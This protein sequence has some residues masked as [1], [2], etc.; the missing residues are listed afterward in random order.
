M[1]SRAP[2]IIL[3]VLI[4][5]A[6]LA[7]LASLH[8]Q[9]SASQSQPQ[10][11]G[12]LKKQDLEEPFADL[13]APEM[14][15]I[16]AT[17]GEK[18]P[19]GGW[20]VAALPDQSQKNGNRSPVYVLNTVSLMASGKVTNLIVAGVTLL[21]A[22]HKPVETIELKWSLI[23]VDSQSVVLNGRTVR[24]RV[25]IDA[26]RARKMKSP[27]VNFARISRPLVKNGML[28]GNYQL[29]IGVGSIAFADGSSWDDQDVARFNHSSIART[30]YQN[31]A[32][33]GDQI[34]G[35]GPQ[36][37]E[38][39]CWDQPMSGFN[40]RLINCNLQEGVTYCICDLKSCNDTCSFTQAQEDACNSQSCHVFDEFFC[41][42]VDNSNDPFC[43]PNP[44]VCE[45]C[46][47]DVQCCTGE[48]CN[49]LIEYCVG[50]YY[51]GCD[52][53]FVDD[54]WANGGYV[55]VGTCQ[56]SYDY[57]GG[58]GGGGGGGDC[59]DDWE[60]GSGFCDLDGYCWEAL[61]DPILIDIRG[62]GFSMTD[63]ANGVMFDFFGNGRLRQ[64][65]WTEGGSD[66]AWLVFDRDKNG[67]I[68]NG[69]ELFSNVSP[70]P[71]PPSGA[72]RI[73]F[74][75]LAMFDKPPLGG[76]GDGVIDSRD[77]IFSKLRLWQDS[78]HNGISEPSE[79]HTLEELG[80]ES[81]SLDYRESRRTDRYGN[82]FRYRAKVYGTNHADLGRWAY[83]VVLLSAKRASGQ[84]SNGRTNGGPNSLWTIDIFR[85]SAR[86]RLGQ[87]DALTDKSFLRE[88]SASSSRLW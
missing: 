16:F 34:C 84:A 7:A 12:A 67:K 56:C 6:A 5:I 8:S 24:F 47:A 71:P 74:L 65:S 46:W 73:G 32:P 9:G 10:W 37:G 19:G 62:N 59:Y 49:Y 80:V 44:P 78:N 1:R 72:S 50:N 17:E 83:D 60:C 15:Q 40:C 31:Q 55:P 35:T 66:D 58:G 2:G 29:Q 45:S 25:D 69:K 51:F 27:Y 48:H 85:P 53:H 82:T 81:I 14:A 86:R 18:E 75:A 41:D 64:I 43:V 52:D 70:Q 22:A 79:L 88:M 54:C 26:R 39:Q 87:I 21:N 36:H 76:N 13:R 11:L 28:D 42:C 33:C 61:V 63:A 77:A 20:F 38:A 3:C 57:G 4:T 68:V 30:E 23:N